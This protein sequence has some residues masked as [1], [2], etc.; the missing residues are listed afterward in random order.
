MKKINLITFII[1]SLVSINTIFA[2]E[3]GKSKIA[4]EKMITTSVKGSVTDKISGEALTGVAVKVNSS[5]EI[6]YTDFE[7]NFEI[8]N[9]NTGQYELSISY[10]SYKNVDQIVKIDASKSNTLNLEIEPLLK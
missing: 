7:G 5:N 10:I 1:V 4:G 9:L 8:D 2:V 3:K 6:V